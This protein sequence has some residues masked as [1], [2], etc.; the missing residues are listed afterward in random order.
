MYSRQELNISGRRSIGFYGELIATENN[1][2]TS[3]D[4]QFEWDRVKIFKID[5]E[6][7]RQQAEKTGKVLDPYRVGIARCTKMEGDRDQYRVFY[8]K[9]I[10]QILGV[11]QSHLPV[12]HHKIE[13]QLRF[14][15]TPTGGLEHEFPARSPVE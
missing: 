2:E 11:M 15:N 9:T 14:Y 12:F 7:A 10:E 4:T 1:R 3:E 13:E 5:P 6:W 8:C